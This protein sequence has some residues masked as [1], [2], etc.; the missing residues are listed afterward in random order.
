MTELEG[1]IRAAASDSKGR[2]ELWA[3]VLGQLG[4]IDISEVGVWKGEFAEFLLRNCAGIRRYYMIDPWRHLESWNKPFNRT[5]EE[6]TRIMAEALARTEFAKDKRVVLRGKLSEVSAAIPDDCL[7]YAYIDGDHT[8]RGIIVDLVRMWPKV[9]EGGVLAGDD[10]CRS[11]W[12]HPSQFE[13]TLV[14]PL[15]VY[16]AE[17]VGASIYGLP[18]NQYAIVRS[19]T[20]FAFRDLT[21][22]YR[23]TALREALFPPQDRRHPGLGKRV[24]RKLKRLVTES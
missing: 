4:E 15:A 17:A 5:D 11:I 18:F 20:G 10:F 23:S 24:I 7:D 12:E 3:S 6:F 22:E 16:F 21:G 9:R 13:P 1:V 2:E 19:N 8:A 14:F